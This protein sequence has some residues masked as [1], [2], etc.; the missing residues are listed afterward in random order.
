[1]HTPEEVTLKALEQAKKLN[2]DC[3]VSVSIARSGCGLRTPQD[4]AG[5]P[6]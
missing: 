4:A 3:Y 2:A 5:G 6:R 1:M